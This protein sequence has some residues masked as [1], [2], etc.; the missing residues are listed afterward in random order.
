MKALISETGIGACGRTVEF[1][2]IEA[3]A[4][5]TNPQ[6]FARISYTN[7]NSHPPSHTWYPIREILESDFIFRFEA[8]FKDGWRK[9]L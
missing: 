6:A 7:N 8:T 4:K 5:T 9:Q 1:E 2:T 3:L